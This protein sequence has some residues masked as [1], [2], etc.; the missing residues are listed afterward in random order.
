MDNGGL[1]PEA[2]R[3]FTNQRN[4]SIEKENR[5][6]REKIDVQKAKIE[7]VIDLIEINQ[8][9]LDEQL[10]DAGRGLIRNVL[11]MLEDLKN[12]K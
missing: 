8:H 10:S 5:Q 1:S 11:R 9:H 6:L 4:D 12:G 7:A 2:D 3:F